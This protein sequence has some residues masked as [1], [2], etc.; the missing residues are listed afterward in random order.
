VPTCDGKAHTLRYVIS[1]SEGTDTHPAWQRLREGRAWAQFVIFA[2]P[3]GT[4]P[5]NP[6]T[7][8]RDAFAGWVYVEKHH[9]HRHHGR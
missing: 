7:W 6:E 3:E 1:R 8:T 5:A 4:D 9:R 2:A